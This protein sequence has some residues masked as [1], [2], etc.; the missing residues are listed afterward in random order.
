[1]N[2]HSH[3]NLPHYTEFEDNRGQGRPPKYPFR[4]LKIGE[5]VFL[6]NKTTK[7]VGKAARSMRYD[8]PTTTLRFRCKTICKDGVIGVK[9]TRVS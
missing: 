7:L 9:L 6:P 2:S 8:N 1:M 3:H 5:S 4:K